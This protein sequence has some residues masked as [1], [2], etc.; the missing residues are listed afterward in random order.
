MQKI[1]KN[2]KVVKEEKFT[3]IFKIPVSQALSVPSESIYLPIHFSKKLIN[4]LSWI[5]MHWRFNSLATNRVQ[6]INKY[7]AWCICFCF[8]WQNKNSKALQ[9]HKGT[10]SVSHNFRFYYFYYSWIIKCS[11]RHHQNCLDFSLKTPK[12]IFEMKQR[13]ESFF[14]WHE[15]KQVSSSPLIML[16]EIT[17][18]ID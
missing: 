3:Q 9:P 4:G 8:P 1:T 13:E 17:N 6:L 15:E 11:M 5:G 18:K 14:L 12:Y 10:D 7:N 2:I 16:Q